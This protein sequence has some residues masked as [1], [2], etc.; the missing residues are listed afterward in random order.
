M[1][2]CQEMPRGRGIAMRLERAELGAQIKPM[3]MSLCAPHL[4]T[5]PL[6]R[7]WLHG[8]GLC[9]SLWHQGA[10]ARGGISVMFPSSL[11]FTCL[12]QKLFFMFPSNDKR[13]F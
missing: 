10:P 6:G 4:G 2:Q 7:G 12:E 9:K 11:L 5:W 13:L 8:M 3:Q 1:I